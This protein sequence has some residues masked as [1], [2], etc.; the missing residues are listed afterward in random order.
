L[1]PHYLRAARFSPCQKTGG[2][3]VLYIVL[4]LVS[5]ALLLAVVVLLK[6]RRLRLALQEILKRILA[7]WRPHANPQAPVH[8]DP[9]DPG[10]DDR[11]QQGPAD[12]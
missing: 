5:V 7:R 4:T 2:A 9:R 11:V 12:G 6:E 1:K 8:P 10:G 3:L